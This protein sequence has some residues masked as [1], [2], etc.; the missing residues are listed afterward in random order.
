MSSFSHVALIGLGEVGRIFA[1]DLAARGV[2]TIT[3]Y[4]IAFTDPESVQSQVGRAGPA[5]ATWLCT[6]SGSAKATS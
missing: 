5:R 3:A 2:A 1:R 4:D 6:L